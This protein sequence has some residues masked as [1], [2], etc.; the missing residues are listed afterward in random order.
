MQIT[1]Q[2]DQIEY[3]ERIISVPKLVRAQFIPL[4]TA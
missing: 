4:I 2:N 1:I 3:G